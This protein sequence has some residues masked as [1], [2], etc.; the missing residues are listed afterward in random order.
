MKCWCTIPIP[1]SMASLGV[2]KWTSTP[3]DGDGALV[4][5]HHPVEDLH[6]GRLAGAVLADDGVDLGG[7]PTVEL[8]VFVGNDPRVALGHALEL[9][10][11]VP[12][13]SL[14]VQ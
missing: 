1:A 10:W 7:Q 4:R 8:D 6:Q 11:R 9:E 2:R 3:S 5:A 14:P 12:L 13:T